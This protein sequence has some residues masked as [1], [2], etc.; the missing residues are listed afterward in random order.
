MLHRPL[1][2]ALLLAEAGAALAA[3]PISGLST[4]PEA[5]SALP[6]LRLP[7]AAVKTQVATF[8]HEPLRFA[9]EVPLGMDERNGR[10]DSPMPGLSRW[11]LR[12]ESDA[13]RSLALELRDVKLPAGAELWFYDSTGR[14]VQGPFA[15]GSAEVRTGHLPLVRG[16]TAVLEV[17]VPTARVQEVSFKIASALHGYRG[18]F[19][20]RAENEPKA[21]IGSDSESCNINVACTE[22]DNWRNEIRSTVLLTIGGTTLCTGTLVN[23]TSQNDRPLILTANHCGLR[24][25]NVTT[26]RAY[27][28]TQSATCAGNDDG[29]TDQNI[30]GST[31]LARDENSDFTVFALGSTPPAAYNVYYAGWD[32]R[33]GVAP[34]SGVTIHHPSGDEKKISVYSSAGSAQEDVC[35]GGTGSACSN[36]FRVDSWQINWSRG[37]TEQGSSGSGLFNQNRQLVGVLSG[38]GASCSSQTQPDFFG[39]LERAWQANTAST[40]QLKAHLDP[41]NTGCLQ[42]ASKTPGVANAIASC[43]ISA[44]PSPTPTPSTGGGDGGGGGSAGLGLI[45]LALAPALRRRLQR[46]PFMPLLSS[47]VSAK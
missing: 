38:G 47:G 13:A 28:N 6:E 26:T 32:V 46:K 7:A 45:A 4:T 40:G 41:T 5:L 15:P 30:L 2:A 34:Q 10:W 1:A 35:I 27:F 36:G 16:H 23:N 33:S 3:A 44:T 14:D 18:L 39:R 21:A 12:I 31:F 9:V 29:R 37:T 25:S 22:G 19:A 8:K 43:G 11:Q 42:L 24:D 17:L 20:S